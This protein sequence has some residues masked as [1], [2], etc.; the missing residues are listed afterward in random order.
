VRQDAIRAHKLNY[1][2]DPKFA[3]LAADNPLYAA[4]AQSGQRA[5]VVSCR[6]GVAP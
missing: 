1:L 5:T 2:T 4:G 6:A 3:G